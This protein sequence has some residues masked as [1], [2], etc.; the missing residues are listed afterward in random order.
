MDKPKKVVET[1][2]VAIARKKIGGE[3]PIVV[4][5]ITDNCLYTGFFGTIDSIRMLAITDKILDM[6]TSTGID[7]LVIDLSNIDIIDS[8]VASYLLRLGET[9]TLIGMETIFC[10]IMPSVAQG[11]I[12]AGIEMRE[13]RISRNLK[14]AVKLVFE[15]QGIKLVKIDPTAI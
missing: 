2:K 8:A 1:Q 15:L 7:I 5:E 14:S 4:N 3:V 12:T 13:F 9:L 11:M 6:L 10:G